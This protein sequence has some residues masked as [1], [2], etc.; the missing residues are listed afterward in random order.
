MTEERK[1]ILV[2]EDEEKHIADAKEFFKSVEGV[3]LMVRRTY[4]DASYLMTRRVGEGIEN[5][6][7]V[8]GV[9]CD[10]YFPLSRSDE[11]SQPEA[12][13]VRVATEL[14]QVGIP[15]V[16]NTAGYHDDPRHKWISDMTYTQ[17]WY[18]FDCDPRRLRHGEIASKDWRNAWRKLEELMEK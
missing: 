10:T 6:G 3:K 16:L 9:I 5:S 12:I 15:F 7:E 11:W 1:R 4:E 14:S 17:D 8:D 2:I 18:L 13:G